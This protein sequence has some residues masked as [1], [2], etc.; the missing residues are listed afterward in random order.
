MSC[1]IDDHHIGGNL[2]RISQVFYYYPGDGTRYTFDD[3][4]F[5]TARLYYQHLDGA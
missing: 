4:S 1:V 3:T 2:R 5:T